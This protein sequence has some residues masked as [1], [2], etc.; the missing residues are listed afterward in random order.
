MKLE[1]N[2]IRTYDKIQKHFTKLNNSTRR[3]C[4]IGYWFYRLL[5][6]RDILLFLPHCSCQ[7]FS[8]LRSNNQSDEEKP[9]DLRCG[10]Y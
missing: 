10:F 6:D 2:E 7:C 4:V 3:Y 1:E 5:L 8:A 9:S